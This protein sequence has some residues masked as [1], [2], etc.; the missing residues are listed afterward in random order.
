MDLIRPKARWAWQLAA[1][2]ALGALAAVVLTLALTGTDGIRTSDTFTAP[3]KS[4]FPPGGTQP[5]VICF[6]RETSCGL[7]ILFSE[8][9]VVKPGQMVTATE[10][11][12]DSV[13]GE[14]RVAF[15]VEPARQ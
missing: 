4:Y 1:A 9:M 5:N 7:P 15:Y 12:F 6:D 10:V 14:Q 11:R 3:V 8:D 13:E 2:G